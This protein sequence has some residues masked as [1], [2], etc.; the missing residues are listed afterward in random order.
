MKNNNECIS[1]TQLK[2]NIHIDPLGTLHASDYDFECK[3]FVFQKKSITVTKEEM[4]KV[5]DDNYLAIVDTTTL[6]I[7]NL[8]I[9]ITAN[10]PDD[11]FEG[12]LRKEVICV[13]TN[14]NIVNCI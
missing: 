14:I 4:V 8:H 10:V 13:P 2:L 12:R 11:D 9:T 6:G 1:G 3:F 7:G 5:D